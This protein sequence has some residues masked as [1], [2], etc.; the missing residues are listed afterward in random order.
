MITAWIPFIQHQF[1]FLQT[2][3][4]ISSPSYLTAKTL[5]K[6]LGRTKPE[7]QL[8]T[9][10]MPVQADWNE[11]FKLGTLVLWLCDA[12]EQK[13]EKTNRAHLIKSLLSGIYLLKT[14]APKHLSLS[15]V[16]KLAEMESG[17]FIKCLQ[18]K[19]RRLQTMEERDNQT[20]TARRE[21]DL[22]PVS[23]YHSHCSVKWATSPPSPCMCRSCVYGNENK[24]D[25]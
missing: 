6:H 5:I 20:A 10:T 17:L 22:R 13:I 23:G 15:T 18:Q 19:S 25:L 2:S 11:W 7:E 24:P 14:F 12:D 1:G 9:K 21:Y 16:K 8:T 4:T 3:N